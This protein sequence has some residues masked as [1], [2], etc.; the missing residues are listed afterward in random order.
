MLD[1][2]LQ[3]HDQSVVRRHVQQKRCLVAQRD[4]Q[5]AN[6]RAVSTAATIAGAEFT[7]TGG[8][9]NVD[10]GEIAPHFEHV[11]TPTMER[12][13]N[14][15]IIFDNAATIDNASQFQTGSQGSIEVNADVDIFDQGWDWDGD[16]G[17]DNVITINDRE[18]C[19]STIRRTIRL[20]RRHDIINGGT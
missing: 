19:L 7:Q 11:S 13:N 18:V 1:T 3:R 12:S 16:G 6:T 20:G 2:R 8:S 17:T 9:I 14:G 4:A 5:Y 15:L 10:A